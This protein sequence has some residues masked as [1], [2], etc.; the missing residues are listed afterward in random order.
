MK[1]IVL[2]IMF[3]LFWISTIAQAP[4]FFSYQAVARDLTGKA[5]ANEAVSFKVSILNRSAA[6]TLV[7]SET[8]SGKTTNALGLVELETGKGIVSTGT[9]ST[10]GWGSS[11]FSL[12]MDPSGGTACQN[13]GTSQLL[14]APYAL[15]SKSTESYSETDPVFSA[16][17]SGGI[18]NGNITNWKGIADNGVT[19]GKSQNGAV[20]TADR[21]NGAVTFA[22]IQNGS[23]ATADLAGLVVTAEKLTANSWVSTDP[24]FETGDGSSAISTSTTL[25]ILKNGNT[26]IATATPAYTLYANGED[27]IT[28]A[29]GY[30]DFNV[31]A[32]NVAHVNAV[33][34]PKAEN[35]MLKY[36]MM[37]K[38]MDFDACLSKLESMLEATSN[39]YVS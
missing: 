21:A 1:T 5:L 20:S 10:I 14:S 36:E 29:D 11:T 33:K 17:P 7:Y 18:M 22:K 25:T 15:H 26:G 12:K 28:G 3:C 24:L 9:F 2:I 37:R 34:E 39:F 23:I 8:H 13:L 38:K 19:S 32:I 4:Q 27:I 35:D 30:F 6:G 31:H 16:S